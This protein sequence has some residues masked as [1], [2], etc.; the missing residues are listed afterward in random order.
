LIFNQIPRKYDYC[1]II[2][3][4][5]CEIPSEVDLRKVAQGVTV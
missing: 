3:R 5:S 1:P 4:A 2:G